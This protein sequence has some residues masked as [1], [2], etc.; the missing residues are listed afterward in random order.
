MKKD[1]HFTSRMLICSGAL[2]AVSGIL[3][4][5]CAKIAYGGI[6]FAAASCMFFAARN[7]R[8]KEINDD[9]EEKKD[10]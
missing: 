2:L 6:F 4:A 5:I 7:F 1:K 3:F 8:I 9:S 10:E